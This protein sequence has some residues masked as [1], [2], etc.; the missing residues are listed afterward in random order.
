MSAEYGN[1][2][3]TQCAKL[4]EVAARSK[5]RIETT[6][7]NQQKYTSLSE[8]IE[9]NQA[10]IKTMTAIMGMVKPWISDLEEY[11]AA[12]KADALK[13]INSALAVASFVVPA[14]MKGI[15][16]KIEGREAWLENEKG[17]DVDRIEGSGYKGTVSVYL[18]NIVLRA[19]PDL[20]QFMILDEPLSKLHVESAA[21]FSTYVPLLAENMQIIWIEHKKEVFEN[22]P[23]K[24][25]YTFHVNDDN[26]TTVLREA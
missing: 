14:S 3:S 9:L 8:Q 18:R 25:V 10:N 11:N 22:T 5:V 17:M 26:Y 1:I 7:E 6:Q 13:A 16:F 19:N 2:Y 23:N 12:K 20:L 21:I 15:R 4:R 24:Y